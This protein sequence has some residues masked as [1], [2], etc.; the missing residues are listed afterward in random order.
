MKI[1]SV[2]V[3]N[4]N[5]TGKYSGE[6]I[7]KGCLGVKVDKYKFDAYHDIG[8][9]V[10]FAECEGLLSVFHHLPGTKDGFAGRLITL[11]VIENSI[12]SSRIKARRVKTFK[13]SLWDSADACRAVA[14]HLGCK[15]FSIGVR[16]SAD[17]DNLYCS[18]MATD[19]FM[20]RLEK[21]VVLG[22]PQQSPLI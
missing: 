14:Q 11:P 22:A 19:S 20:Q 2:E 6:P 4:L 12:I 21:V 1:F 5:T 15:L 7:P 17:R 3:F 8:N 13:G 10:L 9:G 16:Q 18:V